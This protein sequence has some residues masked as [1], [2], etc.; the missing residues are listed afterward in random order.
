[1]QNLSKVAGLISPNQ[2][3]E[4]FQQIIQLLDSSPQI[5]TYPGTVAAT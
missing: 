5:N 2:T 1:M 3:K 4:D